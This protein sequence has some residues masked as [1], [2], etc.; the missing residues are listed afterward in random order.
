MDGI[1]LV[2]KVCWHIV[3][4]NAN[5]PKVRGYR[6][7]IWEQ[8][9]NVFMTPADGGLVAKELQRFTYSAIDCTED[10]GMTNRIRKAR[11]SYFRKDKWGTRTV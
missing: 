3:R 8:V 5:T 4:V 2:Y 1:H 11:E 9:C 7:R 10:R 6:R